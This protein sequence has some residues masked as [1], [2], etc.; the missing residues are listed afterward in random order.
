[1]NWTHYLVIAAGAALPAAD[2]IVEGAP[3]LTTAVLLQALAAGAVAAV[4]VFLKAP[5]KS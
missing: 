3:V 1:M 2:K 5:S 4:A